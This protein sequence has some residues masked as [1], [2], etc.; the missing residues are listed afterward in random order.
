M[1]YLVN[2]TRQQRLGQACNSIQS[3]LSFQAACRLS[4]QEN[5]IVKLVVLIPPSGNMHAFIMITHSQELV[6]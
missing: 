5:V 3:L 4:L 6:C 1:Q 2:D